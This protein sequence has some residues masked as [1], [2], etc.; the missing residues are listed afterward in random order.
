MNS[1][2]VSLGVVKDLV[3]S[4]D[5]S[6]DLQTLSTSIGR[7]STVDTACPRLAVVVIGIDVVISLVCGVVVLGS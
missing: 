2:V 1:R 7:D 3:K 5:T 4:I 6:L